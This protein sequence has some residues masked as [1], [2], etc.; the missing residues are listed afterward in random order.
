MA[1]HFHNVCRVRCVW[2]I[3]DRGWKRV[4]PTTKAVLLP[5]Q[6]AFKAIIV[7]IKAWLDSW[8]IPHCETEEESTISKAHLSAYLRLSDFLDIT[9]EAVADQI[10]TLFLYSAP[11]S[12]LWYVHQLCTWANKQWFEGVS[13]PCPASAFVFG[14]LC[15]NTQQKCT[16]E[17]K[18]NRNSLGSGSFE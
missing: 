2:H 7:Q 14:S 6:E 9:S 1:M 16:D 15:F 12:P 3:V 4:C 17:G 18:C 8:M 13:C 11:C 10:G 5:N